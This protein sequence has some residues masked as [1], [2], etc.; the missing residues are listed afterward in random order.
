MIFSLSLLI[1]GGERGVGKEGRV[2]NTGDIY[3]VQVTVAF[4]RRA[5]THQKRKPDILCDMS[6]CGP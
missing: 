4:L 2:D 6:L 1:R 5:S 3:S